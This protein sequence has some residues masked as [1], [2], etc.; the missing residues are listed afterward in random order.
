MRY[1]GDVMNIRCMCVWLGRVIL[2]IVQWSGYEDNSVV[3]MFGTIINF[4]H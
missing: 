1:Q 4:G 3:S 2:N